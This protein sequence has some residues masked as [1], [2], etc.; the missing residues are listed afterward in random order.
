MDVRDRHLRGRD[1]PEAVPFGLVRVVGEL[2]KLARTDHRC[3]GHEVRHPHLDVAVL[4]GVDVEEEVD[5]SSLQAGSC[6]E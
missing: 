2:R 5:Q 6:S 4:G 1:E 3:L